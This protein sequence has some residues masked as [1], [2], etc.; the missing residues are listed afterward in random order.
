[1]KSRNVE[2]NVTILLDKDADE[3]EVLHYKAQIEHVAD[4]LQLQLPEII[5]RDI[6][7]S[8]QRNRDGLLPL[9]PWRRRV[10]RWFG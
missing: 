2:I 3:K 5:A 10:G 9:S 4:I 7:E 8:L 6:E 1:V